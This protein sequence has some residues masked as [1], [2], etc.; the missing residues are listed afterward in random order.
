MWYMVRMNDARPKDK[1]SIREMLLQ[2]SKQAAKLSLEMMNDPCAGDVA[3]SLLSA[4][5]QA[6]IAATTST[7]DAR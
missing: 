3:A 4:S 5:A 1:D 6:F 7:H 2:G